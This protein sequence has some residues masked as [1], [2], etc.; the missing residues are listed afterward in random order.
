M[1]SK[2]NSFI[3]L[4]NEVIK[5]VKERKEKETKMLAD[6]IA[7]LTRTAVPT[8]VGAILTLLATNGIKAPEGAEEWLA[9]VLFFV[10]AFGYYTIVRLLEAKFPKM[11]W[12]LGNPAKP[13]Y[14][15]NIK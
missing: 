6:L 3:K 5:L 11:G 9:G 12:L 14:N 2:D 4:Q 10:F 13:T 8:L 7:S 1:V 15:S